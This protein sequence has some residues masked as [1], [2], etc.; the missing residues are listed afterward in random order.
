MSSCLRWW[1]GLSVR[2][3]IRPSQQWRRAIWWWRWSIKWCQG[4]CSP[5]SI[6]THSSPGTPCALPIT[7]HT[8]PDTN[9]NIPAIPFRSHIEET[10]DAV[11]HPH[12]VENPSSLLVIDTC[13]THALST[14]SHVIPDTDVT[15][16]FIPSQLQDQETLG[17]VSHSHEVSPRPSNAGRSHQIR[18]KRSIDLKGCI[19]RV[20]ISQSEIES[21]DFMM[22][23]KV[24]GCETIWVSTCSI[25][26]HIHGNT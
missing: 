9:V 14:T 3:K 2:A 23:C 8:V 7:N 12:Q 13:V 1:L 4:P 5:L 20:E 17:I 26:A 25:L 11:S 6:K 10:S 24:P 19:C 18:K 21:S 16:L 15:V 22:N